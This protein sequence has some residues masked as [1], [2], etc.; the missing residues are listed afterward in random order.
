MF[1][2]LVFVL[3]ALLYVAFD[4]CN[5]IVAQI[6]TKYKIPTIYY[7]NIRS[8]RHSEIPKSKATYSRAAS[9]K[10]I[11]CR[12]LS[13]NEITSIQSGTFNGLSNLDSL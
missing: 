10:T 5:L 1:S 13:Y 7:I 8:N 3:A 6:P 2:P 12:Y 11:F 9:T 4:L